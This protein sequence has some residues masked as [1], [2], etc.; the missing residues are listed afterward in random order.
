MKVTVGKRRDNMGDEYLVIKESAGKDF[1]AGGFRAENP[2]GGEPQAQRQGNAM[3]RGYQNRVAHDYLRFAIQRAVGAA[4]SYRNAA[5]VL[6]GVRQDL[7]NYMAGLK[8]KQAITLKIM[9][10]EIEESIFA[11][12]PAEKRGS[13]SSYFLDVEFR[14][15]G[16]LDE[17]FLFLF[18]SEHQSLDI[19][20]KLSHLERD[21]EVRALFLY[22]I[23]LQT[24]DIFRLES[25]FTKLSRKEDGEG[26]DIS[27]AS[28]S[29]KI[30]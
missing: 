7:L 2:V 30:A 27:Q 16:N 29:R 11:S 26:S 20:T 3:M 21:P 23:Q 1:V 4:D 12:S 14:P 13:V 8:N 18:R 15:L 28:F 17:V 19:Y 6:E 25:E 22:L 9:D 24:A 5:M 10:P